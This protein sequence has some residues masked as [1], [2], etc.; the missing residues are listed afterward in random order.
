VREAHR[1]PNSQQG[2]FVRDPGISRSDRMGTGRPTGLLNSQRALRSMRSFMITT[3]F[4]S[5]ALLCAWLAM[6]FGEIAQHST[7][8]RSAG[9]NRLARLWAGAAVVFGSVGAIIEGWP[10]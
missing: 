3:V 6:R 2:C 4:G 5:A 9:L 8:D 7:A 1:E 10:A